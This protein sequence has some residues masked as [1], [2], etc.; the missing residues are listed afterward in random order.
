MVARMTEI[1]KTSTTKTLFAVG[2]AHWTTGDFSFQ[3]LF[4]AGGYRLERVVAGSLDNET[5]SDETCGL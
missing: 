1:M 4:E 2:L 3:K 5:L